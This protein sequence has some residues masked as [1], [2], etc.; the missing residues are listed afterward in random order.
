MGEGLQ[1]VGLLFAVTAGHRPTAQVADVR[2]YQRKHARG[3]ERGD[4][5]EECDPKINI[6]HTF[7]P[8]FN[9]SSMQ[10]LG[11]ANIPRPG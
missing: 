11:L 6:C 1:A 5:C 8:C 7:S 4:S 3:K 10:C 9:G 2:W